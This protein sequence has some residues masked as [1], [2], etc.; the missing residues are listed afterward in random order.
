MEKL[1][2]FAEE[3]AGRQQVAERY[4]CAL[5]DVAVTPRV[6]EGGFGNWAQYTLVLEDRGAVAAAC[7]TSN[8]PTAIYYPTPLHRQCAYA[9]FPTGPGGCPVAEQ[10]ALKVLS[11]PMHPYLDASTQDRIIAAIRSGAKR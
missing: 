8:I 6:I 5:G 9:G 4:T 3:L 1:E 7:H 2:I 11:L 10:L